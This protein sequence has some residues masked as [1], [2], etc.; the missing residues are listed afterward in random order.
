MKR[1]I[2]DDDKSLRRQN[3]ETSNVV[4]EPNDSDMQTKLT[5]SITMRGYYRE[6]TISNKI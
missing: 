4:W 2:S 1:L 3:S 5:T 6:E